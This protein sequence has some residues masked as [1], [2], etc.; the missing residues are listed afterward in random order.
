MATTISTATPADRLD[1]VA[2]LMRN[3]DAGSRPP[4]AT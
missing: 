3:E 4:R 1:R 2:Q